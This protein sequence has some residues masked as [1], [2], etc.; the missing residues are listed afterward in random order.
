[1]KATAPT[2]EME[3]WSPNRDA[4]YI[5]GLPITKPPWGRITAIDM[6]RGEHVWMKANGDGP[7]DHPALRGMDVPPLG[8]ASRPVALVTKTLLFMGEGGQGV[9]GGVQANM[10]GRSFRAYDKATGEVLRGDR[11]GRGH[12]GRPHVVHARREAVHRRGDRRQGT[13]A[14]IRRARASVGSTP[15]SCRILTGMGY[16]ARVRAPLVIA[17]TRCS[18]NWTASGA[19]RVH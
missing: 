9:F 5:D 2:S 1:M 7:R 11:A 4:P 8:V 13:S 19:R 14:R 15:G 12:D 10:W 16:V 17:T 3:Y 18:T 6:N